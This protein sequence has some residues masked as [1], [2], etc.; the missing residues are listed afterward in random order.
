MYNQNFNPEPLI[1]IYHLLATSR[2]IAI[3][4]TRHLMQ[5]CK[6]NDIKLQTTKC[7]M[8][9]VNSNNAKDNEM[10]QI[11]NLSLNSTKCEIYLGSAITN[12]TKLIDDVNADRK[13][14]QVSVVNFFAFLRSNLNAPIDIKIK[15]LNACIMSSLLYNAET[16]AHSKLNRLEVV[17]R[18]MLKSILGVG[19][20]T[21]SEF[22]YI[23]LGVLHIK[24]QVT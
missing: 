4:K 11:D 5:Y 14:R 3:S 23:E 22:L 2:S 10:I 12:S 1:Y 24:I 6:E 9:C 20:M 16:R 7:A 17:Y 13:H 19:M 21:C 8:M 15:V 18:R